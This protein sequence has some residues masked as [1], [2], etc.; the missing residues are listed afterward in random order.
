MIFAGSLTITHPDLENK[1]LIFEQKGIEAIIN[2]HKGEKKID[3]IG[4][5]IDMREDEKVEISTDYED[6]GI[7]YSD[8]TVHLSS[9]KDDCA[10]S[11]T[12]DQAEV[13]SKILAHYVEAY[14]HLQELKK[15]HTVVK[16]I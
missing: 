10:L 3:D 14:R 9:K 12:V 1:E 8:I 6:D 11:L 16:F 4:A 2:T 15:E 7:V 13:L 5:W